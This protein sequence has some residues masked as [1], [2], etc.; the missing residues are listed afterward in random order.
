MSVNDAALPRWDMTPIFPSLESNEF[1]A[2]LASA[3]SDL[4]ALTALFDKYAVRKRETDAVN[5]EFAAAYDAVTVPLNSLLETMR[6]LGS[7]IGCF[8]TVDANDETAKAAESKLDM[9]YVRLS[10]LITRYVA[11]VGAS[12]VEELK[13]KSELAASNAYALTKAQYQARHQMSE[14]EESLAAE[15]GASGISGWA[16]LHG[17]L[18]AL[19]TAK[20]EINGE[21]QTLPMSE[22]RSLANNPD[23]AIRKAAYD[24]EMIAWATVTVPLAAALNGVKGYQQTVR[25]RRGYANDV[26][27]TLL[28]NGIDRPTLDAMQTACVEAFPDFRRY[29]ALKAKAL[30]VE[31]LA[32]HDLLAPL[33]ETSRRYA[34]PEAE[35]VI[36][37]NFRAFSNRMADFADTSFREK[38]IDA[39]PRF[40]KEGGAYCTGMRPGE[41][42]VFMNFD[43]SAN[44][45]STLAHELGHAYHN[46][47]LKDR[48][49]LQ[50]ST[51][52]TLAETASLFCETLVAEAEMQKASAAEKLTLLDRALQ[53][54]CQ[55]VVDIHSRFLFEQSV[56]DLRSQ[57][58]LSAA[59]FSE[60]MLAAQKATYGEDMESYHDKM[61]AVK[62]HYYG[63]LFYNY[64]YTFGALFTI[65]L[66]NVY[67]QNPES[68]RARYDDFLS[69]TGLADAPTLAKNFGLDITDLEFWRGGLNVIRGQIDDFEQLVK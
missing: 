61:W 67:K 3:L 30:G 63:P 20:V 18:T 49:P 50:R 69:S 62:G 46:L 32:W 25:K 59:E 21:V 42:R 16:K 15:L 13:R 47:N 17:N 11:W 39:E 66:Y 37:T 9:D 52:M 1:S 43:G 4:D 5:A 27:P 8:T 48:S 56:F 65:S 24:A 36:R 44:G 54:S 34:W 14:A 19:L 58:D 55:I 57:R 41:S 51:P 45:V 31:K 64:P 33:G 7:Y 10:H 6:L 12:D 38:W 29:M 26:E 23:R 60:K 53:G 68:F 22:I 35:D 28:S 2:A 40:G